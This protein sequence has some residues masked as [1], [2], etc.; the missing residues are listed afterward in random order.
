MGFRQ[1]VLAPFCMLFG[2]RTALIAENLALR[3]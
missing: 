1:V 3:Q 2:N